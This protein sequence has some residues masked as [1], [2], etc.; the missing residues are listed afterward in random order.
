MFVVFI[1]FWLVLACY[2]RSLSY[3][4]YRLPFII[5]FTVVQGWLRFQNICM[6]RVKLS[7]TNKLDTSRIPVHCVL[8]FDDSERRS[9]HHRNRDLQIGLRAWD[10]VRVR[11][12]NLKPVTFLES[13]LCMLVR[14]KLM[15]WDGSVLWKCGT[16]KLELKSLSRIRS[17][18]RTQ[19]WQHSYFKTLSGP[20]WGSKPRS[21]AQ[22]TSP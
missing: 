22:Q 19:I 13:S 21:P 7:K 20:V 15:G 10:W 9:H 18:T 4:R 12:S 8:I 14:G 6:V 16:C 3:Y 5:V 17:R 1:I 11:V 2:S